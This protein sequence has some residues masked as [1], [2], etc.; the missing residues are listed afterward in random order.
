MRMSAWL[1]RPF[2][3]LTPR[4]ALLG[5]LV[6]MGLT[7]WLA[8]RAG[9]QTDGVLTLRFTDHA[10]SPLALLGQG[11]INWLVLSLS[12]LVAGRWLAPTRFAA[13]DLLATQAGARWPMLLSVLYLSIPPVG[14][15]IRQLS[16]DLLTAMPTEPS[17]VMAD[18]L[19]MGDAFLLTL[20]SLPLLFVLG[21]MVWLM[22]HSYSA[23]T[24]MTGPHAVFSFTA[25]LTVTYF[26]TRGLTSLLQ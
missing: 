26:L 16:V 17:Q 7:A 4:P 13:L 23:T 20:L 24:R 21:W 6:A 12:L 22:Y 15:R 14:E 11:L 10:V 3:H 19:Y 18:A 1:F 5:G 8:A 2:D 25:A 9:L